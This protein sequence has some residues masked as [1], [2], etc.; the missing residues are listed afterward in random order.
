M[1]RRGSIAILV[2]LAFLAPACG[3][4]DDSGGR[5]PGNSVVYTTFYPMTYFAE[6]IG[7]DLVDVVCP[8]PADEDAIF[9]Q[10]DDATIRDYQRA[11]LIV[12]NG[13][14]FEKWLLK[15][16]LPEARV[17]DSTAQITEEFIEFGQSITHSHGPAGEHAHEG[18]DGHT[19][20]DPLNAIRQAEEI[21]AGLKVVLQGHED[22][23]ETRCDALVA[24]LE[25]LDTELRA[26]T[27]KYGGQP[28]LASH[29]AYNY[30]AQRYEWNVINL[31]LD[32]ETMP[33]EETLAG[34]KTV[35]EEN[36]AKFILWESAPTAEIAARF[37]AD[38]GLTSVV[39]S[40][41]EQPDDA[42]DYLAIMKRN[43]KAMETVLRSN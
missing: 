38:L 7:G 12:T 6:R 20:L 40:P 5:T 21:C 39:F 25:A 37:T 17:V 27:E 4:D 29:P 31:D 9:W 30:L 19:W 43:V 42:G 10:P 41:C 16:S 18:I 11:D 32:P 2:V 8:L 23:L 33:D 13:A 36:P 22:A 34:I 24:E 1:T 35:L 14:E 3:P 28:I 15:V 26:L